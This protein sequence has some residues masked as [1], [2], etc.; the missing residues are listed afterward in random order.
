[1][2]GRPGAGSGRCCMLEETGTVHVRG[3]FLACALAADVGVIGVHGAGSACAKLSA[4]FPAHTCR[5]ILCPC[6]AR[7]R[8]WCTHM[9]V[10]ISTGRQ[11]AS[12]GVRQDKAGTRIA[13]TSALA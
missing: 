13:G 1:M 5:T 11:P 3:V 9:K 12:P 6:L 7:L 4:P 2:Q 10:V 8:Q